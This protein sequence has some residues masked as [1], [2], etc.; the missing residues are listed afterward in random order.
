LALIA[1]KMLPQ[2]LWASVLTVVL[3]VIEM[4]GVVLLGFAQTLAV[5]LKPGKERREFAEAL[6]FDMPHHEALVQWLRQ[7]PRKRLVAMSAF[8]SQRFE[9]MQNKLPLL[10]GSL[11]K[12]GAL[13]VFA[14]LVILFKDMHWPPQSSW[15]QIFLFVTLMLVYWVSLLQVGIRF[16]L[17]LY[18]VLLKKALEK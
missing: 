4:A 5:N 8:A 15:P 16:R 2:T 14:A 1:A 3:L 7:F 13:P 12:L 9:R 11:D 17:E 18:D 6:D 10:I